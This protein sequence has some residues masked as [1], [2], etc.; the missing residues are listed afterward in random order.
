MMMG[1]LDFGGKGHIFMRQ[2]DRFG[3]TGSAGGKIEAAFILGR[4]FDIDR[5]GGLEFFRTSS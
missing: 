5:L 4:Q 1:L 2:E 3:S